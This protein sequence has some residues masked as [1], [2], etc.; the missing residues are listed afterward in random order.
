M[1]LIALALISVSLLMGSPSTAE[2]DLDWKKEAPVK[3]VEGDL[4]FRKGQGLWTRFFINVSQSE[5]RFSHVGIVVSN[6]CS[7]CIIHAEANEWNGI[8]YV[9]LQNWNQFF[10]DALESAVFRY[11]GDE[12]T[13]RRIAHEATKMLHIP[14]DPLF[15]MENTNRLYCT[16]FVRLAVNRA[17]KQDLIGHTVVCGRP[18]VAIDDI[19]RKKFIRIYDSKLPSERK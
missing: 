9:H 3:L 13:R 4:I 2:T 5:K 14:F 19:Y 15:D 17:L 6:E 10:S 11:D 16:E 8:G 7:L 12:N 18:F 1:R